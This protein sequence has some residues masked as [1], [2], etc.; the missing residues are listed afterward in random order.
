VIG[1]G[2][3]RWRVA[4]LGAVTGMAGAACQMD[5]GA[6]L[7][8]GAVGEPEASC[9]R[10]GTICTWAGTGDPA[11]AGDGQPRTLSP[12]YWPMDLGFAPDGRAYLLDWQNHRLRRVNADGRLETVI[13]NDLVGDGPRDGGDMR[14]EGAPGWTVELNHPTDVSFL[15]DGQV[16]MAAWHNHKVRQLEP[17]SNRVTVLVGSGAGAVGDGGAARMA[18]LNQ[19][20]SVVA[21]PAGN[22]FVTD[23]RNKR[24][25][26]IDAASGTIV[27]VAGNGTLG[28][29]GDG[30]PPL[31][32]S[33]NMQED[34]ENPEP[35][36]SI[37]YDPAEGALYLADT[38][39]NRVRKVDLSL[40]VVTT[41][42]G[43]GTRGFSGDGG[44]G[45]AAALNGPRDVEL[46]PDRHLYIADTDNHRIRVL[47][48]R[49]GIITTVAGQGP[50]G[51]AGDRGPARSA[52]FFR[53]WGIAHGPDGALYVADTRNNRIRRIAP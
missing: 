27:T 43:S 52:R 37:A 34:N 1:N 39:N 2:L 18:L 20:K 5:D 12:L 32:A 25:R 51:F 3:G 19:P 42:A 29:G 23:S 48:R 11:F 45:T 8:S 26:R 4:V 22:V 36:G 47:D 9:D 14:P 21:D 49:T 40:Q 16:L 30:G 46:G 10:S 7:V 28:F 13:G 15:P 53:P 17:Q 33:F 41:V 6:D 31:Q 24:L 35:G 50:P 44:P 38:F